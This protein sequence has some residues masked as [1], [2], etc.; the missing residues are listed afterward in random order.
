[1]LRLYLRSRNREHS[2][3]VA[4][5]LVISSHQPLE[6]IQVDFLTRLICGELSRQALENLHPSTTRSSSMSKIERGDGV[7]DV[8]LACAMNAAMRPVQ[9]RFDSEIQF[10]EK[11]GLKLSET[12][13]WCFPGDGPQ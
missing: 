10:R 11:A 9:G 7:V 13:L 3:E 5:E 4:W 8:P 12:A 1:M 6:Q 2:P